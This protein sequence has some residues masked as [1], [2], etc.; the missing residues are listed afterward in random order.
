MQVGLAPRELLNGTYGPSVARVACR[1]PGRPVPTQCESRSSRSS[2]FR[3]GGPGYSLD[4][5]LPAE[6]GR[7]VSPPDPRA[8]V[9]S[10]LFL[11]VSVA[12]R[13][14]TRTRTQLYFGGGPTHR[15]FPAGVPARLRLKP[16][17]R[18]GVSER[19]RRSSE[20]HGLSPR[21]L[22]RDPVVGCLPGPPEAPYPT[23]LARVP[24][25]SCRPSCPWFHHPR[26]PVDLPEEDVRGLCR[27]RCGLSVWGEVR[28]GLRSRHTEDRPAGAR[29]RSGGHLTPCPE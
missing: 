26:A 14:S 12:P 27:R 9:R 22:F 28:V 15:P 21:D 6:R 13:P 24:R 1:A 20:A 17:L 4:R 23:V 8:R 2:T 16:T 3:R 29:P 18:R 11:S 10:R 7:S 5:S 25:A 19:V